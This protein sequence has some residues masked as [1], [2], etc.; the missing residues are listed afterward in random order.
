[1]TPATY[2]VTALR[3]TV[4]GAPA[5]FTVNFGVAAGGGGGMMASVVEMGPKMAA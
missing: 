2:Q 1:V 5:Q 3:S 4:A